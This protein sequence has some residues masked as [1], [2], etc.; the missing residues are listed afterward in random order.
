[1]ELF[2]QDG[3]NGCGNEDDFEDDNEGWCVK[4]PTLSVVTPSEE[5]E[6]ITPQSISP[7]KGSGIVPKVLGE[8]ES[9]EKPSAGGLGELEE[10]GAPGAVGAAELAFTGTEAL[11]LAAIALVLASVGLILIWM[12]R[13]RAT[14]GS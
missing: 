2:D 8:I 6:V 11:P 4:P 13:R 5:E 1:V 14:Q 9:G 3:N 7:P 12:G 10:A